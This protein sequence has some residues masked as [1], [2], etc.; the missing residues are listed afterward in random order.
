MCWGKR[1]KGDA[2]SLMVT[3]VAFC[4]FSDLDIPLANINLI[5]YPATIRSSDGQL[6]RAAASSA[7]ISILIMPI[8]ASMALG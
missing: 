6:S 5:E 2:V 4:Y 7:D 3:E 1:R 8:M